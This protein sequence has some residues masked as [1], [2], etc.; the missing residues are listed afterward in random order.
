MPLLLLDLSADVAVP[1][2]DAAMVLATFVQGP[3]LYCTGTGSDGQRRVCDREK[4]REKRKRQPPQ[5]QTVRCLLTEVKC[6]GMTEGI[7]KKIDRP[8]FLPS[9]LSSPII[10]AP[11]LPPP[12]H[13]HNPLWNHHTLLPK[14]FFPAAATFLNQ[15]NQLL[16]LAE[17]LANAHN[18]AN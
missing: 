11:T 3:P 2:L 5:N 4:K 18:H 15:P 6:V 8:F 14:P 7:T 9:F 1:V 10:Q 13:Y 12:Q 17:R 16:G